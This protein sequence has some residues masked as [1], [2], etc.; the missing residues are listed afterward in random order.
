MCSNKYYVYAHYTVDT[1]ELFYIGKGTSNRAYVKNKRSNYWK[2]IVKVH[3]FKVTI[4]IDNLEESD[5]FIQEILAIK[6]FN[7]KANF[8]RG[9]EGKSGP[10][11]PNTI[12]AVKEYWQNMPLE[13]KK[14][15]Q[16]RRSK[17]RKVK[18]IIC[19]NTGK[20]YKTA[21][22]A[23]EDLNIK[24]HQHVTRAANGTR[25]KCQN[26]KFKYAT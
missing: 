1:N 25:K 16:S 26:Y 20:H 11:H 10:A 7:P 2:N 18:G 9:G 6:E 5:A 12:K 15:E 14:K 4:L 22:E 8:T 17:M 24:Y 3:G 13:Q 19:I 21:K 23:A